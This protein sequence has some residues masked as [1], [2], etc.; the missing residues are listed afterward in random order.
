MNRLVSLPKVRV[1]WLPFETW[2]NLIYWRVRGAD[3]LIIKQLAVVAVVR[4]CV[5]F[6]SPYPILLPSLTSQ[7]VRQAIPQPHL[8]VLDRAGK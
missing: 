1:P 6:V 2:G 4:K 7:K 5:L 8:T 3:R